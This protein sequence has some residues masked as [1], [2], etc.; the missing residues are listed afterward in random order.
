[1]VHRSLYD[2]NASPGFLLGENVFLSMKNSKA[3]YSYFAV[4]FLYRSTK[5][6]E[7]L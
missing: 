6:C 7:V 5:S 2:A 1:M 3:A 4:V